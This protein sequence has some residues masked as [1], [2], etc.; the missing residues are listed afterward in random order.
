MPRLSSLTSQA[1]AGL[2]ITRDSS[3]LLGSIPSGFWLGDQSGTTATLEPISN[4]VTSFYLTT[5]GL[6]SVTEKT[7]PVR[8]IRAYQ[9]QFQKSGGTTWFYLG[10]E[11]T[12]FA[13]IIYRSDN[14][15]DSW[16]TFLDTGVNTPMGYYLNPAVTTSHVVFPDS[17]ANDMY[18]WNGSWVTATPNITF[19]NLRIGEA[20][21]TGSGPRGNLIAANYNRTEAGV[22][23]IVRFK[24]GSASGNEGGNTWEVLVDANTSTAWGGNA[25]RFVSGIAYDNN[26]YYASISSQGYRSIAV[27]T[28][29]TTWSDPIE[30]TTLP[31]FAQ[32]LYY[33]PTLSAWIVRSLGTNILAISTSENP[34]TNEWTQGGDPGFS[35]VTGLYDDGTNVLMFS[36][37]GDILNLQ[38]Y[39]SG[40]I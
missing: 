19:Q 25:G 22:A 2:G 32:E 10:Y 17:S 37:A 27:S 18:Y 28:D 1:L 35:T 29:V 13:R 4:N 3:G 5:D 40:V 20:V 9:G 8:H 16:S 39:F 12:T 36:V 14:N 11:D 23:R 34:S 7:L 15:G 6:N 21:Y 33:S 24:S 31:T 38:Q 26:L 30:Q